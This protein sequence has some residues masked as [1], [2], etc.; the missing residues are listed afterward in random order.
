MPS[1]RD[2][3]LDGV[4]EATRLHET[5]ETQQNVDLFGG[6]IDVFHSILTHGAELLFRKLEGLL[7]VYLPAPRPGILLTTERSL[8]I[9]R[10]TPAHE[11]RHFA[12]GH[13][14]SIDPDENLKR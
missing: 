4:L 6:R 9:Q 2:A 14:R 12:I 10:Y 5:L 8:A 13:P 1:R 11:L 3:V 7:R